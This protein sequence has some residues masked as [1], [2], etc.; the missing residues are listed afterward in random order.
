M[1]NPKELMSSLLV[2]YPESL[3]PSD[4]AQKDMIRTLSKL[5]YSPKQL[6][7]LYDKLIQECN[8]FP[9][10]YDLITQASNLNL[11][12]RERQ[13][14]TVF[15]T[16][17]DD[18]GRTWAK[19]VGTEFPESAEAREERYNREVIPYEQGMEIARQ[20]MRDDGHPESAVLRI[21]PYDKPRIAPATIDQA[22]STRPVESKSE[23]DDS[24]LDIEYIDESETDEWKDF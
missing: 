6:D 17:R 18:R 2:H 11:S 9:K 19:P 21:F 13:P 16:W 23:Y 1:R 5:K 3:H 20:A 12:T 22:K 8:Y 14:N 10:V 4:Q 24:G 15:K 7:D